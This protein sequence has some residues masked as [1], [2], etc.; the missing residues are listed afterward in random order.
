[1]L[2]KRK[3][4]GKPTKERGSESVSARGGGSASTPSE[5]FRD[6][7]GAP[8][9]AQNA[10]GAAS[11]NATQSPASGAPQPVPTT[12]CA[13]STST[14]VP[15]R[16]QP[17]KEPVGWSSGRSQTV[18]G[19][20]SRDPVESATVTPKTPATAPGF[21]TMDSSRKPLSRPP[22]TPSKPQIQQGK[23]DMILTKYAY[24][25]ETIGFIKLVPRSLPYQARPSLAP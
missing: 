5:T 21:K 23:S 20:S 12:I 3:G 9:L 6:L 1:M 10:S 24:H 4:R 8:A 14:S 22:P 7:F 15:S 16:T 2:R 17:P 25:L 13:P 18:L 11:S 19:G